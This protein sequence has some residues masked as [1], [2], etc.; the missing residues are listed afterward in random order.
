MRLWDV[1]L[2]VLGSFFN[3]SK[4]NLFCTKK[5]AHEIELVKFSWEVGV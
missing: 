3:N 2:L 1:Q 4:K 5:Q